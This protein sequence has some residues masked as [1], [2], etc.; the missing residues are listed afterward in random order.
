MLLKGMYGD[1]NSAYSLGNF[2]WSDIR[3][4]VRLIEDHPEV[5]GNDINEFRRSLKIK[6]LADN[7]VFASGKYMNPESDKREVIGYL[8]FTELSVGGD[9]MFTAWGKQGSFKHSLALCRLFLRYGFKE[10][11]LKRVY[12]I[13]NAP[14]KKSTLTALRLGFVKEGRLRKAVVINNKA[15]DLILMSMFEGEFK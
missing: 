1:E 9:A 2:Y 3:K 7:A 10:L 14:N 4:I 11:K 13:I 5:Y 12:A 6:V 15:E 8:G